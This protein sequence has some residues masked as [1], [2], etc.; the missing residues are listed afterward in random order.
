MFN[1]NNW[2]D[3]AANCAVPTG[4]YKGERFYRFRVY[5][6]DGSKAHWTLAAE[7]CGFIT[8]HARN[9]RE[10]LDFA[11]REFNTPASTLFTVGPRGGLV[12]RFVSYER[13]IGR[14]VLER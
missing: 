14:L 10:A 8:V 9:A 3:V 2:R 11:E 13:H 6:K 7:D 1:R 4:T 12:H 5:L